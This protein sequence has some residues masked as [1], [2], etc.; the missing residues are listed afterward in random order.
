[1]RKRVLGELGP[2]GGWH[3]I[4]SARRYAA[5]V[6][7]TLPRDPSADPP[8][9][10]VVHSCW[11]AGIVLSQ[12][13]GGLVCDGFPMVG[14]PFGSDRS[15]LGSRQS[16]CVGHRVWRCERLLRC[17]RPCRRALILGTERRRSTPSCVRPFAAP[18]IDCEWQNKIRWESAD[19]AKEWTSS[20]LK[21]T[22][23][24]SPPWAETTYTCA[25]AF[26]MSSF[27]R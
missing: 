15:R 19:H 18:S 17:Q 13:P 27:S 24:A 25:T 7:Y 5:G 1:M 6:R 16:T 10:I 11:L 20:S 3:R 22:A 2:L 8:R 26:S 12:G 21:L 9:D 14:L 23:K 4:R